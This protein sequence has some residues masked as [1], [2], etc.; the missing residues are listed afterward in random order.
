[1]KNSNSTVIH[2]ST[3]CEVEA[4]QRGRGKRGWQG[5]WINVGITLAEVCQPAV[6]SIKVPVAQVVAELDEFPCRQGRFRIVPTDTASA[7]RQLR[8]HDM[9]RQKADPHCRATL[10]V[11]CFG[12]EVRY[13]GHLCLTQVIVQQM[14]PCRSLL[15]FLQGFVPCEFVL[16]CLHFSIGPTAAGRSAFPRG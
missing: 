1:M 3:H 4:W 14:R 5:R 8:L 16:G 12:E 2:T 13:G 10:L 11:V 9:A 6:S 7:S 15:E